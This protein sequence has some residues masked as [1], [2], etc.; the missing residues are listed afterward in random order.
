MAY[1]VVHSRDTH[2]ENSESDTHQAIFWKNSCQ[3]RQSTRAKNDAQEQEKY[4]AVSVS[5]DQIRVVENEWKAQ[6][7]HQGHGNTDYSHTNRRLDLF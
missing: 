4:S 5:L 3:D 2:G 7:K 6:C 1:Q